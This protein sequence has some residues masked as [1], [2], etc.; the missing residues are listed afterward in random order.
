MTPFCVT[1]PSDGNGIVV[2]I[3]Q[4][5]PGYCG[6]DPPQPKS[7]WWEIDNEPVNV[8]CPSGRDTQYGTTAISLAGE[9]SIPFL[10]LS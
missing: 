7:I 9:F 10:R 2:I 1:G 3:R 5:R 8:L 6:G 4:S